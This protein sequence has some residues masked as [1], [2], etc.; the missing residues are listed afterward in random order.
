[1]AIDIT[2]FFIF[3]SYIDSFMDSDAP[4]TTKYH[5]HSK[6]NTHIYRLYDDIL[7]PSQL[8]LYIL[9]IFGID[10]LSEVN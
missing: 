2:A 5:T 7:Y 4:E 3:G 9:R 8:P 10:S 1:M 6:I